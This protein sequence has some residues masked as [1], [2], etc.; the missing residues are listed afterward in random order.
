M[1]L[2][3]CVNVKKN[4]NSLLVSH[5]D[6]PTLFQFRMGRHQSAHKLAIYEYHTVSSRVGGYLCLDS[7]CPF[8]EVKKKRKL[9]IDKWIWPK[10][11]SCSPLSQYIFDPIASTHHIEQVFWKLCPFPPT[12]RI[13]RQL[14]YSRFQL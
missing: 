7:L 2:I 13:Q 14:Q 3:A 1:K 11:N 10:K 12:K 5:G 6:T 9:S 8:L 4:E